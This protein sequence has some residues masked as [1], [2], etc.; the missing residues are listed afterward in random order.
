MNQTLDTASDGDPFPDHGRSQVDHDRNLAAGIVVSACYRVHP[1]YRQIFV[2]AVIP[3]MKAA[4]KMPGRI[5]CAFAPDPAPPSVAALLRPWLRH[6]R[7]HRFYAQQS[8][9][10]SKTEMHAK[11][12]EPPGRD[13]LQDAARQ[14]GE[15]GSRG[16]SFCQTAAVLGNVVPV[17]TINLSCDTLEP[18]FAVWQDARTAVDFGG[19]DVPAC[20]RKMNTAQAL[21]SVGAPIQVNCGA[22]VMVTPQANRQPLS[23]ALVALW[24]TAVPLQP[25]SC[26]TGSVV[27]IQPGYM[28]ALQLN[29]NSFTIE[30]LTAASND[31]SH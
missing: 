17:D 29:A 28:Q 20:Y 8:R 4:R 9:S 1:E 2:D 24:G 16:D 27:R 10:L 14:P 11:C 13:R 19:G 25:G 12:R 26:F 30:R 22:A 6:C 21:N 5:D 3:G 18:G 23:D 15:L 7:W 31:I